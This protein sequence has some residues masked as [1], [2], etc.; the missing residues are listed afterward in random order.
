M[1]L[2]NNHN[3]IETMKMF[4]HIRITRVLWTFYIFATISILSSCS[5]KEYINAI[6]AES[7]MLIRLNPTKLSGAKSPLILKTLLHV[8]KIDGAGIDLSQDVYFLRMV[9][10]ISDYVLRLAATAS[11]RSR[12]R[13]QACRLQSVVTISLQLCHRVG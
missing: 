6:P 2:K 5:G 3:L 12:Y 10:A 13:K 4:N 7:Q 1:K 11:L 8:K 9:K